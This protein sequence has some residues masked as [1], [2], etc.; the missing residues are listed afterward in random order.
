MSS[1]KELLFKYK[2]TGDLRI[3][4]LIIENNKGF[5]KDIINKKFNYPNILDELFQEGMIALSNCIEKYDPE[6]GELTTLSFYSIRNR[7]LNYL[8]KNQQ[9]VSINFE[10]LTD[11]IEAPRTINYINIVEEACSLAGENTKQN[12][13]KYVTN[14]PLVNQKQRKSAKQMRELMVE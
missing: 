3:K 4:G 8:R 6:K 1:N 11:L 13:Y 2:Q 10:S 14:F 12:F 5:I 7:L 9:T